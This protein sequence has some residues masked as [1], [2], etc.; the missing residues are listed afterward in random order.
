MP[1]AVNQLARDRGPTFGYARGHPRESHHAPLR[2]AQFFGINRTKPA[3]AEATLIACR[4]PVTGLEEGGFSDLVMRTR[5]GFPAV[6]SDDLEKSP[7]RPLATALEFHRGAS[8]LPRIEDWETV[9]E[10][11]LD[12]VLT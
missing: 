10:E 12:R 8:D 5:I 7:R 9:L 11:E 2:K 4:E 3:G 1:N 6:G